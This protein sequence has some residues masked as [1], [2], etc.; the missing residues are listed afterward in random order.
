MSEEFGDGNKGGNVAVLD[1]SPNITI[2]L[3]ELV[4]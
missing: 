2:A 4:S 1:H 3:Y